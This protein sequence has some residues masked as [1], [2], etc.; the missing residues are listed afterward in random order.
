MAS[1]A[2]E[3]EEAVEA[4]DVAGKNDGAAAD[5]TAGLA[6]VTRVE[7]DEARAGALTVVGGDGVGA[8]A[9]GAGGGVTLLEKS[10]GAGGGDGFLC[11]TAATG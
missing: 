6:C 2:R 9:G 8:G 1:E 7:D 5:L 10:A 11:L 4:A 3:R